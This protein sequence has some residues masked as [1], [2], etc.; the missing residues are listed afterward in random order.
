[1]PKLSI[2]VPIYNVEPYISR[3]IDS[4]L[5]Q[6]FWN[7]ELILINDGSPDRCEKIMEE[8]A[9]QDER[10]ILIHQENKGVSAARN[11]GLNRANG[12]YI[13]FVD[14]DDWIEPTMYS[15]LI[16][17]IES[18]A[19][20]IA[21]CSWI[22]NDENGNERFYKSK[23]SSGEM[24]NAEYMSHLF[25][26]PPTISGSVCSKLF[27]NGIISEYFS[28]QY[29]ICEDNLFVAHCCANCKRAVYINKP[30]YH[31]YARTDSATRS[32]PDKAAFGLPARREI[33]GVARRVND[34]CGMLAERLFL[35]Q[36]L[37]FCSKQRPQNTEFY[38]LAKTEFLSYMRP[39]MK[40][41]LSNESVK[42]KTKV[43]LL[44]EYFRLKREHV[45]YQ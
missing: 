21:S 38:T 31:V 42:T 39:N 23:L 26:M 30:L 27:R 33:I 25:D 11:A 3:C 7:F 28:E 40:K 18:R 45:S 15:I 9:L 36:C 2:I 43:Y 24:D 19:A 34:R 4:I 8:Y 10:V 17:A 12:E 22:D 1:M 14:P 44:N 35:D 6:T 5:S 29:K 41:I 13:G 16:E 37:T 20:D 32:V